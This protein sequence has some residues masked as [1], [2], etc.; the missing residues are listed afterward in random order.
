M[1]IAPRVNVVKSTMTS[2]L[3]EFVRM[4]LSIFLVTMVGEDLYKF[5]AS[6]YTVSWG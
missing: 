1:G 5:L 2:R 3:R 4:N 6:V